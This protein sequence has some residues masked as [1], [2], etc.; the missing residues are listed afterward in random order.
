MF[1]NSALIDES[2]TLPDLSGDLEKHV[3]LS[4]LR[5]GRAAPLVYKVRWNPI[6]S[7][8]PYSHTFPPL[9]P[10]QRNLHLR[11]TTTMYSSILFIG[12]HLLFTS[13]FAATTPCT[14]QQRIAGAKQIV[15]SYNQQTLGAS[16]AGFAKVPF[17]PNV[18]VT[19]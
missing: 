6:Q 13:A 8:H 18:I 14:S 17:A 12:F 4:R 10:G 5:M 16:E 7:R 11:P 3:D 9:P 1:G 19:M 2:S 15:S